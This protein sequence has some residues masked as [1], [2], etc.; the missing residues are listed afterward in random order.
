MSPP[1]R[2]APFISQ[3]FTNLVHSRVE[4]Y[5]SMTSEMPL[6]EALSKS[7]T[8]APQS[9]AVPKSPALSL[10]TN[11]VAAHPSHV[12]L[13]AAAAAARTAHSSQVDTSSPYLGP[14][15]ANGGAAAAKD[16][17][18]VFGATDGMRDLALSANEPRY[19]PGVVTRG[20]RKDSKRQDSVHESDEGSGKKGRARAVSEVVKE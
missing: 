19:F 9:A 12:S 20:H 15:V 17:A 18:G 8:G 16:G 13:A 5:N 6:S 2:P 14:A 11:T 4:R 10:K 3:S 1:C 7:H